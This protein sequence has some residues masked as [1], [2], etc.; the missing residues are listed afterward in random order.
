MEDELQELREQVRPLQADKERLQQGR[1]LYLPME[2]KCPMFRGRV[3]MGIEEWVEEVNASIRTRH[4]GTLDQA[5]FIFD[6]LDGDTESRL[7]C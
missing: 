6:H 5:Y 3:G 1:L 2:R 4:L 7:T